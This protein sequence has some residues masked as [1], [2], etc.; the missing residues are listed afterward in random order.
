MRNDL[1]RNET[2]FVTKGDIEEF[3]RRLVL[4]CKE[5]K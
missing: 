4:K 1:Y 3:K 5:A 2:P